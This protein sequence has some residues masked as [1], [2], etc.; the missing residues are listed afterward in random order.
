[1][2]VI[3]VRSDVKKVIIYVVDFQSI[4]ELI[5]NLMIVSNFIC[6]VLSGKLKIC[7]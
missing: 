4:V 2:N 3:M 7:L 1:M 5:K 6:H